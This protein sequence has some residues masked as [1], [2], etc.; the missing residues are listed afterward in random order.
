VLV[1]AQAAVLARGLE[2]VEHA[3]CHAVNGPGVDADG[4]TQGGGASHKLCENTMERMVDT[5]M[6]RRMVTTRMLEEAAM[7]N[8]D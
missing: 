1:V 2:G 7:A 8:A 5:Y 3:V 4:A 6:L